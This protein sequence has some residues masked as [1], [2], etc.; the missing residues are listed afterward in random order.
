MRL[1]PV[2]WQGGSLLLQRRWLSCTASMRPTRRVAMEVQRRSQSSAAIGNRRLISAWPA[3]G[4]PV[5]R[6][7]N[8]LLRRQHLALH[9]HVSSMHSMRRPARS[10]GQ[11]QHRVAVHQAAAQR[12]IVCRRRSQ[13]AMVATEELLVVPG[14]RSVPAVFDRNDGTLRYFEINAGGKGTRRII[15]RR[16]RKAVL[17]AYT[18]E[19]D[20]SRSISQI[21]IKTAFMPN[22]PVLHRGMVYSAESSR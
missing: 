20:A 1:P 7:G 2:G 13:G 6:D 12:S 15:R 4:G 3:R 5:I 19:R 16:R 9:G 8:G 22:E 14:G 18:G 17:R 11:R 21:G 10:M